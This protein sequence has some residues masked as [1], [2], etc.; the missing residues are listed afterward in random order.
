MPTDERGG[1]TFL[2][3]A[4]YPADEVWGHLP[5]QVLQRIVDKDLR[6]LTIDPTVIGREL[7]T[8][9]RINTIM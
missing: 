2:V 3:N 4:P 6:V 7:N 9:G 1:G 5:H 8:P